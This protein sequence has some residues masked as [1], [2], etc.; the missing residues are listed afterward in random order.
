M[1]QYE[2]IVD[3]GETANKC[4]IMPLQYRDDFQLLFGRVRGPLT[5]DIL[6]HHEGIPL[7]ELNQEMHAVKKIGVIDCVWR[8]LDPILEYLDRPLPTFVSIPQGFETAYPRRSKK[9]F[10]PSGGLATI[11][12]IFIAA[13]FLGHWD[14]SLLREY[15]FAEEFLRI[16]DGVF[17]AHGINPPTERHQPIFNPMLPRNS[18]QRRVGR[19]RAG[20]PQASTPG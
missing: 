18:H 20:K 17:R 9:D 8:R 14:E 16:N 4:T 7:H 11:E 12:A 19:G 10:D 15:F 13:A 3:H 5:A 6:L 1:F 2:I